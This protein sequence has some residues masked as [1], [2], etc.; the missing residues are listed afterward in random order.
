MNAVTKSGTNS[1]HGDLFEFLRNGN[2]DARNFFAP[3]AD[4]LRRNQFG[5]VI[6]GPIVKDRVFFFTGFQGTTER[7][8]PATNI[9]FVPTAA[10]LRGNFQTILSPPCQPRP[11][12]L[13][14][15][16][17]AVNNI[18]PASALNPIAMR[19]L[20]LL[21]V[22]TDPCGKITYGIP[23]RDNEYQGVARV[24]WQRRQNDSIFARY[25]ITDY[26][27][28]AFYDKTN[29]LTAAN[30][31]LADR[32][33]SA[34]LGD[35]YLINA[36]TVN[37]LRLSFSGSAVNRVGAEGVPTMTQLGSNVFS[38]ISNY[39]GQI[40]VN[41][42]FTSGAIPGYIYTNVY[43]ISEDL[44][45]TI[46][47][48]QLDFGANWI[49]T[50][51]N[52][53]GPFQMNPRM[54]FTG[55]LTGNSLADFITGNLDSMLQGNGQVGRDRQNSPSI[56]A[57]DS[58]K[59]TPRFQTNMGIR[60]DPFIPQHSGYNYA[61]QFDPAKF[62]AGQVSKVYVNAPPGLTFPG[63]AGFPGQSNTY[64]RYMDF[65]PRF[66][67]VFDPR[68]KGTEMIRAGYGIFYDSSYLWNTLHIPLNPPWGN[69]ITLNAPSGGLSNPWLG[70]PGGD[71]FPTPAHVPST[72]Q[73][74]VGGTYVFQPL[75]ARATCLQQWNFSIQKQVA[76]DWLVSATYIGNKTTHQWL[77]REIDP[78]IYIPGGPCTLFGVRY[79]PCSSTAST[80]ARRVLALNNPAQG[81][82]FGSISYVDDGGNASYNGL[83]LVLQHRF[84]HNFSA[85][86]IYTWSH[87]LDQGEA[88][89]D[90]TNLY[91]NP[92]D[93]RAEWGNCASDRR[94][95]FN[96]SLVAQSPVYHNKWLQ[97]VIGN[98]T[99]SAI[100]T[101][102][103]G[104]WL[105][106]IDGTDVPLTGAGADRPNV[107]A[108]TTVA[109]QTINQWFNTAAFVQQATGTYGNTGRNTILG[110]GNWN[111]DAALWRSFPLT[112]RLRLDI[113]GEG[114]NVLNHTRWGTIGATS[115][116]SNP[117][118]SLASGT[119]FG[120]IT[121]ALD[122]RIM[123]IAMKLTF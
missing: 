21:P 5:G 111:L 91:Q 26:G 53:L 119:T 116:T 108:S 99:T 101:A 7:T 120:K 117:G 38:P 54:T 75:H 64:A 37:S 46:G 77:S 2:L 97:M 34:N 52:A 11:V 103:S 39:T 3:T 16:S 60:W 90:I 121:S 27:L 66:G 112:E 89:Q 36:K 100:F 63:D 113:R 92:Y 105:N 106:V 23:T 42:Y 32:V 87:C 95:M 71:P 57:Q 94:Q 14:A 4:T 15:S 68:G 58:W 118:T 96:L 25:F 56:Y 6:G 107:V 49:N 20:A 81:Q 17:G 22:S 24:D 110:P 78:A 86:A 61:S 114:F 55:Q 45:T 30:V 98:W 70:Y 102:A 85:L 122:P 50:Q 79:N 8:A 123:Q 47:A 51:M 76:R 12:T 35:T 13:T 9:A 84:S 83:L 18:L 65:A 69:S 19:Y 41:G 62:Y 67:I 109:N 10:V 44:G 33:Q 82:Y 43:S 73:F 40:M 115:A 48:H 1:F 72:Y 74:P 88:N 80:N 93:R 104:A 29:L 59:V 28:D 31:G